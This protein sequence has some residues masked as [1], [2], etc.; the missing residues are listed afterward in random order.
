M[1]IKIGNKEYIGQC[2]ALSYIYHRKIFDLNIFDEL[3][4]LKE[5]IKNIID[6]DDL[7]NSSKMFYEIL[8]R[9]IYTL[10]YTENKNIMSFEELKEEIEKKGLLDTTINSVIDIYLK[11]FTD[12]KLTKELE[13]IPTKIGQKKP[14]F[15]EHDF[16]SNCF[17]S[18]ISIDTLREFTYVDIKKMQ[19][20]SYKQNQQQ[21]QKGKVYIKATQKDWD[22]LAGGM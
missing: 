4:E 21:N 11:S 18:G 8:V 13:K 16:L 10:I 9:L 19:I 15:P 12:E 3:N 14:V 20:S 22:K 17:E 5:K 1:K 7:Q 6:N 2:N